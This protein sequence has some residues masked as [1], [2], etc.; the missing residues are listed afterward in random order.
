MLCRLSPESQ[1]PL[2]ESRETE[3]LCPVWVFRSTT[4]IPF[5]LWANRSCTIHSVTAQQPQTI[6]TILFF[7]QSS[8]FFSHLIVQL[9]IILMQ[10]QAPNHKICFSLSS[11]KNFCSWLLFMGDDFR[12]HGMD[13]PPRSTQ[14]SHK[15]TCQH[16]HK[17]ST[18]ENKHLYHPWLSSLCRL[19]HNFSRASH[20]FCITCT[21]LGQ[22]GG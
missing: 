15:S 22:F 7:R 21:F 18:Q 12:A 16:D 11:D 9:L 13:H 14:P 2:I 20:C 3:V 8:A 10:L 6:T 5:L 17:T 4:M 19:S 1:P